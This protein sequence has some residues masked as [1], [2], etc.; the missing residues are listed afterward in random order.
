MDYQI[1]NVVEK[2]VGDLIERLLEEKCEMCTCEKCRA[3]IA[4]LALN[5]LQPRYVASKRGEAFARADA[6][7]Q[8]TYTAVMVAVA[9]AIKQVS[10]NPRHEVRL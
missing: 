5:D 10:L 9:K 8:N 6:L 4:A 7:G 3:D 2:T 1:T